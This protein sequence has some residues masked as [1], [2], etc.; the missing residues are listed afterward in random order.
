MSGTCCHRKIEADKFRK[1]SGVLMS[2]RPITGQQK[3]K[4]QFSPY[5]F[6]VTSVGTGGVQGEWVI[7]NGQAL[8]FSLKKKEDAVAENRTV[9]LAWCGIM[10]VFLTKAEA[11]LGNASYLKIK[12]PAGCHAFLCFFL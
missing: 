11:T 7:E 12:L 5:N 1:G 3:S 8:V 6:Y 9:G 4:Q 2:D 10:Y